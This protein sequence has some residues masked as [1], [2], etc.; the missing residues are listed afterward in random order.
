MKVL[1][2]LDLVALS[3]LCFYFFSGRLAKENV[4]AVVQQAK[5]SKGRS[6]KG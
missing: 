1:L 2:I 6:T 4:P 3:I 5:K